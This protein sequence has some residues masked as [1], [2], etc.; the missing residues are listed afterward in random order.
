MSSHSNLIHRLVFLTQ[1]GKSARLGWRVSRPQLLQLWARRGRV[2][3][4]K[5]DHVKL[6]LAAMFQKS[7]HY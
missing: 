5:D 1:L 3:V 7:V 2:P 6:K 4:R